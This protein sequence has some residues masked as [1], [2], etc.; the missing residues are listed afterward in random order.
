MPLYVSPASKTDAPRIAAIHLAAFG[1]NAMLLAQFPTPTVR[2]KLQDCIATKALADIRDPNI[3]VL[4]VRDNANGNDKIISFAKWSLPV[5]QGEMS[6][7]AKWLW[8]EGTNLEVLEEWTGVV[9]AAK[10]RVMGDEACYRKSLWAIYVVP[11]SHPLR[12]RREGNNR[13]V[14]HLCVDRICPFCNTQLLSSSN[15][16]IE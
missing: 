7:E 3:A 1:T 10:A 13:K 12:V 6:M 16:I 11:S 2:E 9:E 5:R 4:V 15:A 14:E 8:P